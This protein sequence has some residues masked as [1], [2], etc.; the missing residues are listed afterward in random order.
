MILTFNIQPVKSESETWTVDN[1][2]SADFTTIQEAIN[3]ATAGDTI[4]V[5]KGTY[6][7]HVT[8][9]KT[10]SLIGNDTDQTIV[11]GG[12]TA[13]VITITAD[14]VNIRGFTVMNSGFGP[15]DHGITID[16]SSGTHISGNKILNNGNGGIG[17]FFSPNNTITG[18]AIFS[19]LY[20]GI[21]LYSSSNNLISGNVIYFNTYN[22]IHAYS[23][24][25]NVIS[26]NDIS[27]NAYYGIFLSFSLN[28]TIYHN[29]LNNIRQASSPE[30]KNAWDYEG[31]GNFWSDYTGVDMYSG[32]Y[33]NE[34][35]SDGIGDT[36]YVIDVNNKDYFPL[37][38]RFSSFNVTLRQET[39]QVNVISNSAISDFEFTI[40][41]ETG[42]KIIRFNATSQDGEDG[43]CRVDLP[44]N[45]ISGPFILVVGGE[46]ITSTSGEF[47]EGAYSYLYFTYVNHNNTITIVSSK[48]LNLYNDL[49]DKSS[50]LQT[51]LNNLNV[52]YHDILGQYET[53]LGN[54]SQLQNSYREL[55]NSYQEHLQNDAVN[56][57]NIRN[58]TYIIA[59]TTALFIITAVYLS[60]SAFPPPTG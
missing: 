58:L 31:E 25:N 50:K 26:D 17:L 47:L 24:Y 30:L 4:L 18:N 19:N 60:K 22:G 1:D 34:T 5:N 51:D 2:G 21:F 7:E 27:S 55:N 16:R 52:T 23:S 3:N 39:Y 15:N 11:N 53:L 12:R 57:S 20:S 32:P 14:N 46:E 43:F 38:G 42:N 45:L 28:N 54:Y 48:T 6:Y 29:N 9:N 44:T 33:Q 13:S 59:V 10:I 35:G 37:M 41:E 56:V 49:A 40:G 36:E 8:V